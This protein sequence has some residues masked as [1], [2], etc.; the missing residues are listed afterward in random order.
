MNESAAR[1]LIVELFDSVYP[2]L[3]RFA[4]HSLH[5]LTAAEDLAQES[6]LKL[7][8]FVRRGGAVQNPTAW[9]FAVLRREI[10]AWAQHRDRAVSAEVGAVA[11]ADRTAAIDAAADLKQML[12]A[13]TPREAEV[14][15]LRAGALKHK[16]I[17][18][19]LGI[20]TKTV[21]VLLV[22]AL[23]KLQRCVT[24]SKAVEDERFDADAKRRTPLQ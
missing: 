11:A 19:E 17:A 7:Y 21:G 12:S 22:R 10:H 20:N 16:E 14:L 5:D 8:E 24:G 9:L 6:L 3:V 15:M 1:A 23:R 2:S 18:D 4:A 13:L